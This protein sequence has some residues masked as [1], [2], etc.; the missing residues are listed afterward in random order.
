MRRSP[1]EMMVDQACGFDASKMPDVEYVT[2]KCTHCGR[3]KRA[4]KDETDPQG[5]ARVEVACPE[6]TGS[7]DR[8][9]VH[10]YDAQDR[11]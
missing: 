1:I 6:C 11:W 4:P 8:P 5:T 3:T 7:G 10:Y 9:E 2:L